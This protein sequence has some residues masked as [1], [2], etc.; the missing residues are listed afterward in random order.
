[1]AIQNFD[2]SAWEFDH[3][4]V[5]SDSQCMNAIGHDGPSATSKTQISDFQGLIDLQTFNDPDILDH[6]YTLARLPW[7][8]YHTEPSKTGDQGLGQIPPLP[9]EFEDTDNTGSSG[10]YQSLSG[11]RESVPC[12]EPGTAEFESIDMTWEDSAIRGAGKKHKNQHPSNGRETEFH[13]KKNHTASERRYRDKLNSKMTELHYALI[14]TQQG[15]RASR[16]S[17]A[18]WTWQASSVSKSRLWDNAY[19]PARGGPREIRKLD[20][21]SSAVEYIHQTETHIEY[22]AERL[23]KLEA[24]IQH[25]GLTQHMPGVAGATQ[26]SVPTWNDWDGQNCT[27]MDHPTSDLYCG[28]DASAEIAMDTVSWM[29]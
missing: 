26:R 21:I 12:L 29:I 8:A 13:K 20:I 2:C 11:R 3:P 19:Q 9:D 27:V 5:G 15:L 24:R 1:M 6:Q 7:V 22:M 10:S 23:S 25:A 18:S 16:P 4:T 17:M 28:C 14:Q